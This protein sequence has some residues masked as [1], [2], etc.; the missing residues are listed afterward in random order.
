MGFKQ[1]DVIKQVNGEKV[2]TSDEVQKIVSQL[3]PNSERNKYGNIQGRK[4]L[5]N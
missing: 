4:K 2:K 3:K 1:Y 5:F